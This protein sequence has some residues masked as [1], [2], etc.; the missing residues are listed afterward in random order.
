MGPTVNRF[1]PPSPPLTEQ[2]RW[3]DV[4]V[5]NVQGDLVLRPAL[6]PGLAILAAT[7][8]A[9]AGI[10]A[11]ILIG[12]APTIF[13]PIV[14]APF[15]ALIILAIA[16]LLRARITL[17]PQEIIAQGLFTRKRRP[18]SQVTEII[19]ATIIAP[20]GS[21]ESLF[22][23][24]PQRNLLLRVSSATYGSEDINRLITTLDVPC[25]HL[26]T[27]IT[28]KEFT[29]RY[30]GLLTWAEQ[31]PYRL[32]AA[33]LTLMCALAFAVIATVIAAA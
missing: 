7:M 29:N 8:A 14:G 3:D 10:V 19:R 18:R 23:L 12:D 11:A 15:A 1:K 24:G 9:T 21:S 31:H 17:T 22:F 6:I 32:A 20:R 33:M 13:A 27:S 5:H 26:N 30:P 28:A 2:P 16:A 25:T 4:R